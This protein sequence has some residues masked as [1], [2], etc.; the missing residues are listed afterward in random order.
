MEQKIKTAA[1]ETYVTVSPEEFSKEIASSNVVVIDVRPADLYDE[2]HIKNA[3]NLDLENPDF[4]KEAEKI[5]PKGKTIAVYCGLGIH[6]PIA[7]D[8]L[9]KSGYKIVN[10]DG[11]IK[12]WKEAGLPIVK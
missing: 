7:S 4:L 8:K 6:S 3:I 5:L 2:G 11:G 1:T 10:L 12:A 9:A